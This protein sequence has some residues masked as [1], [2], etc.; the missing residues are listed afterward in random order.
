MD[1]QDLVRRVRGGDLHAYRELI[2]LH[3]RAAFRLAYVI[4]G[5]R[6]DAEDACQEAFLA[7][8]RSI[9]RF[10]SGEPFRN[11]VLTIV[12]NKARDR[13]RVASRAGRVEFS[14]LPEELETT[15]DSV[16]AEAIRGDQ[17]GELLRALAAMQEQDRL[18]IACRYFLDLSE[19]DTA[20]LLDVPSGTVKSRLHRAL[21]RLALTLEGAT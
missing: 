10:R 21:T 2:A 12:A 19:R 6:E 16:E 4:T 15:G 11:W 17:R 5:Q 18:V 14:L 20:A 13:R 3:D 7:A 8:Y 1:E 9:H